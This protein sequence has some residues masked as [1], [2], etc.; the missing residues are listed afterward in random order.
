MTVQV[1][2]TGELGRVTCAVVSGVLEACDPYAA[3][4]R[5]WPDELARAERVVLIAAGKGAAGMARAACELLGDRIAR[6]VVIAP[7]TVL[8][9]WP[10]RPG[11]V[12]VMAADH[13]LA[14]QRNLACAQRAMDLVRSAGAGE[15]LVSLISGGASAYLT[16]P[17]EG[18]ELENMRRITDE[19]LRSGATIGEL[20]CVRK[21]LSASKG[22]G[23]PGWGAAP[24][25]TGRWCCRTCWATRST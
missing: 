6:G 3:A 14:T 20:N 8:G 1:Q 12:E 5:A 21:H 23:W 18:L 24:A 13:P 22:A 15:T 11:Q 17:V 10:D 2:A 19:L 4:M 9:S 16:L 25:R 7:E